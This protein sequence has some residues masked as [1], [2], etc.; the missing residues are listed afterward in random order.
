MTSRPLPRRTYELLVDRD[1][2]V[3]MRD[4]ARL[5]A[6]HPSRR[7]AANF[8]PSSSRA[9]P[10]GQGVG[11]ARS[12]EEKPNPLMELGDRESEWWVQGLCLR[13]G[14]RSRQR[15]VARPVHRGLCKRR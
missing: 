4:G 9:L 2:D 7:R 11:P 14:R 10:E 8:P 6:T 13:A 15:Q 3:P 5:K 1:V 12:L